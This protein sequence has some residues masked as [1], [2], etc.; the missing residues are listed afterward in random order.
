MIPDLF[1]GQLVCYN[2]QDIMIGIGM[3]ECDLFGIV[4]RMEYLYRKNPVGLASAVGVPDYCPVRILH[5]RQQMTAVIGIDGFRSVFMDDPDQ[6]ASGITEGES[7]SH[8]R[9]FH[10]AEETAAPGQ[11]SGPSCS[12]CQTGFD[13]PAAGQ[14]N[15][16]S[17]CIDNP[18]QRLRVVPVIIEFGCRQGEDSLQSLFVLNHRFAAAQGQ[19][20]FFPQ[21]IFPDIVFLSEIDL[22]SIVIN[23][24]I[25]ENPGNGLSAQ[26]LL[27]VQL[28]SEARSEGVDGIVT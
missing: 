1:A 4:L 13:K 11:G 14:G 22:C 17:Q 8:S 10:S 9:R 25:V 16:L 5:L 27:Y 2:G 3:V 26:G 21:L 20:Q 24:D 12:V 6:I 7:C 18:K 19:R 15:L 28:P 23:P